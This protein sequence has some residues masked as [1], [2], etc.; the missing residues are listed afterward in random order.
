MKW[1]VQSGNPNLKRKSLAKLIDFKETYE[2]C[3]IWRVR[4]TNSK[5][6]AFTQKYSRNSIHRRFDY[7]LISNT[8]REFVTMTKILTLISTDH[9]LVLFSLSKEKSATRGKVFW[10]FNSSLT[11]DQNY[12]IEIGILIR[13]FCP[14]NE[15]LFN[16]QLKWELLIHE[17]RKFTIWYRKHVAKE[18]RQQRT[19]LENELKILQKNFDEVDLSK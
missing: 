18:K 12:I 17:V 10:N 15:F 19:P 14:K 8:L 4:N 7:I 6:F 2:L 9:S 3:D 5:R 11:K 1:D 13:N 16:R